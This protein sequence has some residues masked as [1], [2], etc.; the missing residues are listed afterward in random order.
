MAYETNKTQL[1][2]SLWSRAYDVSV[3]PL[4]GIHAWVQAK[5]TPYGPRQLLHLLQFGRHLFLALA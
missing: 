2:H 5:D 3:G 1:L 4:Q